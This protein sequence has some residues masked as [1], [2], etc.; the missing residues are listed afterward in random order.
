MLLIRTVLYRRVLAARSAFDAKACRIAAVERRLADANML[1]F[2]GIYF[3]LG[4]WLWGIVSTLIVAS[5]KT[6]GRPG[7]ADISLRDGKSPRHSSF[8]PRIRRRTPGLRAGRAARPRFFQSKTRTTIIWNGDRE[9]TARPIELSKRTTC[10]S[11]FSPF[12]LSRWH[13]L[14]D[15]SCAIV[16]LFHVSLRS[17][18]D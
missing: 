13:D 11:P 15:D 5:A 6:F 3:S 1:R 2:G 4:E 9:R 14:E 8:H 18:R 16:G 12:L 10:T 17:G 7:L